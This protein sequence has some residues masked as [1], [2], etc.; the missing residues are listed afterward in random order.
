MFVQVV[1][2]FCLAPG[3][4]YVLSHA[5]KD[6]A[7]S[8]YRPD[9]CI[10]CGSRGQKETFVRGN[11][12]PCDLWYSVFRLSI[13]LGGATIVIFSMIGTIVFMWFFARGFDPE[14]GFP[15]ELSLILGHRV[16][17]LYMI[18]HCFVK[19]QGG[20]RCDLPKVTVSCWLTWLGYSTKC[21][22]RCVC[23]L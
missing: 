13:H 2:G 18:R 15:L 19:S 14:A 17:C 4:Y 5:E 11:W 20:C 6:T 12:V 23:D 7:I 3:D 9:L 21:V 22:L 1:N 8:H 16:L 10:N